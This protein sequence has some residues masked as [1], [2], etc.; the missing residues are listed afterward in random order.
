MWLPE[1]PTFFR[2]GLKLSLLTPNK[3]QLTPSYKRATHCVNMHSRQD[4]TLGGETAKGRD[5]EFPEY[6]I[7]KPSPVFQRIGFARPFF[8]ENADSPASLFSF[9]FVREGPL[10]ERIGLLRE[11]SGVA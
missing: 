5:R 11:R 3:S 8:Q 10:S 9:Q 6:I 7:P 2:P 1:A 4:S